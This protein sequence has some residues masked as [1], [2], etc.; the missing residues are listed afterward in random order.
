MRNKIL[1]FYLI[2]TSSIVF[3]QTNVIKQYKDNTTNTYNPKSLLTYKNISVVK[4]QFKLNVKKTK[5]A[6]YV[7]K[8]E[9][10]L[11]DNIVEYNKKKSIPVGK[12]TQTTL[13]DLDS[14]I[15][16][17]VYDKKT[18]EWSF[19]YI[20]YL[21][22]IN[23][24]KYYT[25]CRIHNIYHEKNIKSLN[26][27]FIL[28][29]QPTG[30]DN[31]IDVGYPEYFFAIFLNSNNEI[32]YDSKQFDFLFSE[33]FWDSDLTYGSI[34]TSESKNIFNFILFGYKNK[35]NVNW[36]GKTLNCKKIISK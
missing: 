32:I 13:I 15:Y 14:I 4:R 34:K 26:Q 33:E 35:I 24:K 17:N 6:I 27:K 20:W 29:G 12:L 8:D 3:G 2:F 30:Y 5:H 28:F 36:N 9:V 18:K 10:Y 22:Q 19:S 7:D 11:F 16:Y 1:M 21:I 25:D 23:G 31:N